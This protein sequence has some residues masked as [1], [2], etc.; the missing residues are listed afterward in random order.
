MSQISGMLLWER[1]P[2][3]VRA[4][5]RLA[6]LRKQSCSLQIYCVFSL[7]R[8][9]PVVKFC[10]RRECVRP[11]AVPGTAGVGGKAKRVAECFSPSERCVQQ[12]VCHQARTLV[13]KSVGRHNLSGEQPAWSS[14]LICTDASNEVNRCF[15]LLFVDFKKTTKNG[16]P[17]L[18]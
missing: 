17:T 15:Q 16:I 10:A 14:W 2:T 7:A 5:K 4:V 1:A 3:T 9:F 13:D 11:A 8:R 18:L 6:R 12:N